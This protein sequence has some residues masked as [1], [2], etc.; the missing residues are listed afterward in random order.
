MTSLA[1]TNY[2]LPLTTIL[3][4]RLLPGPGRLLARQGQKVAPRD[5]LAQAVL[6]P[7]HIMLD[8]ARG[9]Q[10]APNQIEKYLEHKVNDAVNEGDVIATGP[11][12]L[13]RRVVR[14]PCDGRIVQI[15]NGQAL[16]RKDTGQFELLAGYPGIVKE[17]VPERGALIEASGGLIQ[18]AWGNGHV[19]LGLLQVLAAEPGEPLTPGRLDVSMRGAMVMGGPV[20]ASEVLQVAAEIPLRGMIISS[21]AVDLIQMAEKL[22]FPLIVTEGFGSLPM[23]SA[24]FTLLKTSQNRDVTINAERFAWDSAMRPEILISL[25]SGAFGGPPPLPKAFAPGQQVRILRAPYLSQVGVI[26]AL[27]PGLTTLASGVQAPAADVR[28]DT[29]SRAVVPLANLEVLG[30]K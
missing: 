26:Q 19:D 1:A 14:A 27:L 9:L 16:L 6:A 13:M 5:V 15:R 22:P 3:R 10:V 17:L 29:G 11:R 4:E 20:A 21:L 7:E 30:Y 8:I 2:I 18:A 12:G 23:N 25:P 28:L 24:A